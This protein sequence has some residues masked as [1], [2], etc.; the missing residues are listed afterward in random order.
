MELIKEEV[1]RLIVRGGLLYL[2]SL[3]EETFSFFCGALICHCVEQILKL[4]QTFI[5]LKINKSNI[6]C[7]LKTHTHEDDE[8][9]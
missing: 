8:N 1:L 9:M 7:F 5:N 6:D 4:K 2:V 3:Y